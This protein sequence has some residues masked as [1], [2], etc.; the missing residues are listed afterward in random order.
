VISVSISEKGENI[1]YGYHRN[2]E[3]EIETWKTRKG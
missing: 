1:S 3:K 2:E